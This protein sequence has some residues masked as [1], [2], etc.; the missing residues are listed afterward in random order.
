MLSL[1]EA[2]LAGLVSTS[3]LYGISVT[4]YYVCVRA[5]FPGG[6]GRKPLTL[7]RCILFAVATGM[8][9]DATVGVGQMLRHMLNAFIYYEGEGGADMGLSD[10]RDP[11]NIVHV[12]MIGRYLIMF[13]MCSTRLIGINLSASGSHG[14]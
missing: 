14:R 9:L 3:I 1:S 4:T 5:L 6:S 2:Y 12:R 8:W 11:M 10:I 13:V 7:V